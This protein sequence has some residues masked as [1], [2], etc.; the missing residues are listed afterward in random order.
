MIIA[1]IGL[2]GM[3][4]TLGM[5]NEACK[6]LKKGRCVEAN[7]PIIDNI[8]HTKK[9]SIMTSD[10]G[11]AVRDAKDTL[12]CI[13]E[14]SIVLPNHYWDKLPFDVLIRFAQ[15]R[16]YG[17]DIMYTSQGWNHTV[18]RL[19]DLTNF[20]VKCSNHRWW[21]TF[22]WIDPE[23]YEARVP[24]VFRKDYIVKTD[25]VPFWKFKDIF[26]SYDTM[27]IVQNSLLVPNHHEKSVLL[28]NF[29]L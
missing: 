9:A 14:A 21:F 23:F 12:I 4:K 25:I 26:S 8:Y 2:P 15:V 16:K 6:S 11:G 3:G 24:S 29:D 27:Y 1:F 13:D 5:V 20:V 19:R 18:K 10:I 28:P 7:L 22:E 17:L